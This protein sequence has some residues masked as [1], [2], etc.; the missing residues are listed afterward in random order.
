[1]TLRKGAA[2]ENYF[3]AEENLRLHKK[4]GEKINIFEHCKY[5]YRK[6]SVFHVH[7]FDSKNCAAM[8]MDL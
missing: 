7:L 4:L 6:Y 8:F 2:E 3:E 1:M 5:I